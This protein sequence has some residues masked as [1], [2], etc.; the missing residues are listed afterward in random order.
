MWFYIYVYIYKTIYIY[1]KLYMC[2]Y[3]YICIYIVGGKWEYSESAIYLGQR[4]ECP[5]NHLDETFAD[6]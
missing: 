2:I 6:W 3:I 1:I 5:N 4:I